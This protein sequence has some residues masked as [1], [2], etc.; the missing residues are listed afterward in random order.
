MRLGGG[1]SFSTDNPDF[2]S[3]MIRCDKMEVKTTKSDA[4]ALRGHYLCPM[5]L[6]FLLGDSW[7]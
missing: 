1:G 2:K 4:L 6:S 5:R 7:T 3:I